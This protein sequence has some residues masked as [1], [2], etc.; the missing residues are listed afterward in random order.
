MR[1]FALPLQGYALQGHATHCKGKLGSIETGAKTRHDVVSEA[2]T[3][4]QTVRLPIAMT[5]V[6]EVESVLGDLFQ[7][8][9]EGRTDILQAMVTEASQLP[10]SFLQTLLTSTRAAEEG[11]GQA[12]T[13]LHIASHIGNADAT[14]ALLV[15]G[16]D[17]GIKDANGQRP[18]DL[19]TDSVVC[20]LSLPQ[21]WRGSA[22]AYRPHLSLPPCA[23]VSRYP[24]PCSGSLTAA[25]FRAVQLRRTWGNS[26]RLSPVA[27]KRG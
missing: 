21:C 14:R 1:R 16:A 25:I 11:Q 19:V 26:C 13:L 5:A 23:A 2:L 17:P 27:R 20:A 22:L 6:E 12:W 8:I 3:A 10:P 9:R 7:A 4:A 24:P 15:A 18:I